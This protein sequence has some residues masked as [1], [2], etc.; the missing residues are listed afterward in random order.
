MSS[1]S[2]DGEYIASFIKRFGFGVLRGSSTRGGVGALVE[3]I[4]L[5]R[6][7]LTMGFTLTD[8][9]DRNTS[10][11]PARVCWRKKPAI[12]LCRLWSKRKNTGR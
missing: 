7:G 2:Y 11:K 10:P 5:M 4:R 12:R 1:Q 8:R 6:Q 9:K 3:M